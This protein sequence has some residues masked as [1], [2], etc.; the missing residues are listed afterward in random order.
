MKTLKIAILLPLLFAGCSKPGETTYQTDKAT[1][2]FVG[3]H[4]GSLV[5]IEH[6]G[7]QYL[8]R[9]QGAITHSESCTNAAHIR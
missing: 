9:Y 2:V 8:T 7:H 6:K 1:E 5:E 3:G 4:S